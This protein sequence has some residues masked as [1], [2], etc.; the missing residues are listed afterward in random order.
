MSKLVII[1]DVMEAAM[2]RDL[3]ALRDS[4]PE[5]ERAAFEAERHIHRQAIINHFADYGTYPEI[6][7]VEKVAREALT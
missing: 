3:D 6:G 1:P 7:G 5:G 4:L 2:K